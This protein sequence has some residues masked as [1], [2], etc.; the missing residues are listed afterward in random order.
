ML[1]TEDKLLA[2]LIVGGTCV[3]Q[4]V[5][6]VLLAVFGCFPSDLSQFMSGSA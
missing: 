6:E 4:Q 5:V 3:S 1:E 2:L